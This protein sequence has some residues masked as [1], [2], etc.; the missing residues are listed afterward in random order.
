MIPF[1]EHVIAQLGIRFSKHSQ[2]VTRLIGLVPS[3]TCQ[4]NLDITD[5][6]NFYRDDLPSTVST[7][8]EF[9]R[10]KAKYARLKSQNKEILDTIARAI[11]GLR[12]RWLYKS[13]CFEDCS[14]NTSYLV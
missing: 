10:W 13:V 5:A 6:V 1:L 12:R 14:N 8:G 3:V 9:E 4:R 7:D 2:M 11:R